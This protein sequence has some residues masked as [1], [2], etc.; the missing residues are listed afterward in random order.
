MTIVVVIVEN[1]MMVD[2]A[3]I[4]LNINDEKKEKIKRWDIYLC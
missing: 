3:D 4:D 2:L 1:N